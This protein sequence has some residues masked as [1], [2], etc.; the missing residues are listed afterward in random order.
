MS[1]FPFN[2]FSIFAIGFPFSPPMIGYNSLTLFFFSETGFEG[3]SLP[4][5]GA[6]DEFRIFGVFGARTL[7]DYSSLATD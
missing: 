1:I 6:S 7:E 4:P 2:F 3:S 5:L